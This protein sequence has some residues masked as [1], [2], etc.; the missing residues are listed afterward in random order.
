[1]KTENYTIVVEDM[2]LFAKVC[3]CNDCNLKILEN[4]FNVE[5]FVRGNELSVKPKQNAEKNV[6]EKFA[7]IFDRLMDEAKEGNFPCEDMIK[8]I[9][10]PEGGTSADLKKCSIRIPGGVQTVFAKSTHQALYVKSMQTKDMV[11]AV[12]PAGSG[13]TFLAVAQA[14]KLLLEHKCRKIILTR[15]VVEAGESLGF[16]PGDYE[17]KINPYLR[18]LYDAMELLLNREVLRKLLESG[19]IEVA[20]LAYMRGRTLRDCVA[21]LDEGQNTTCEQM[22]MF[23]T[24]LSEGSKA[25]ITG[26]ITQIDL[27]KKTTSGLVQA[28]GILKNI[29]DIAI[30][31][32]D[33]SDVV[34]SALVK[35]IIQ[36]YEDG[37]KQS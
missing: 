8:A 6:L 21:I 16:L 17:Q 33:A 13:K 18:P 29:D 27:P 3:G 30:H 20:P 2:N 31:H 35:K 34:R 36:A 23:L 24:R 4:I 1:M 32:L 22:K 9:V 15:P 25:F 26:D 12:G 11:F 37:E 28:I 10:L 14:L 5:T 7:F 19:I